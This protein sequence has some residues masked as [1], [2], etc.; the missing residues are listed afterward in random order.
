MLRGNLSAP[1]EVRTPPFF[2][3]DEPG[4]YMLERA[5]SAMSMFP[6]QRRFFMC[7]NK[8]STCP[9]GVCAQK[10][11]GYDADYSTDAALVA[12]QAA[13]TATSMLTGATR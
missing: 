7:S 10:N 1:N 5:P 11:L 3:L 4:T 6:T 2:Q 12:C 9:M 13:P 8:G